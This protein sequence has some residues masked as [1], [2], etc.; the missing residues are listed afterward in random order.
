MERICPSQKQMVKPVEISD[1]PTP[2]P[3][4][5]SDFLMPDDFQAG[6]LTQPGVTDRWVVVG[7]VSLW[8]LPP[9]LGVAAQ[10]HGV[11]ASMEKHQ[12]TFKDWFHLGH[13]WVGAE[14]GPKLSL[15]HPKKSV[16]WDAEDEKIQILGF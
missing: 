8:D 2:T 1:T 6:S 14:Q 9:L 5:P 12:R 7:V 11:V 16:Q 15:F 10:E 4:T 13:Q 3:T